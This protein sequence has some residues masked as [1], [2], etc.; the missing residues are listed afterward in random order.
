MGKGNSI[1]VKFDLPFK[2]YSVFDEQ[3][4]K[5]LLKLSADSV[6]QGS[7]ISLDM[8]GNRQNGIYF[9]KIEYLGEQGI[10]NFLNSDVS[11]SMPYRD[12]VLELSKGTE[13]PIH[14]SYSDKPGNYRIVVTD[15]AT[16]LKNEI[17][18]RLAE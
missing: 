11:K 10:F 2:C 18:V 16:G 12:Q 17:N 15:V 14:F 1:D 4:E 3:Q 5:P 8:K 9:M 6:K 7:A 13:I